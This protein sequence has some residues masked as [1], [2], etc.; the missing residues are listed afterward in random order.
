MSFR[1][2][3]SLVIMLATSSLAPGASGNNDEPL[4]DADVREG[5]REAIEYLYKQ[6]EDWGHWDVEEP[7]NSHINGTNYGGKTA[8]VTYALLTAGESYQNEKLKKAIAFLKDVDLVGTYA[9]AM[10]AHVWAKMPEEY[11]PELRRDL[12]WLLDSLNVKEGTYDYYFKPRPGRVDHSVTQY[13]ML[14]VWEAAKRDVPVSEEYWRVLENHFLEAQ[15]ADGGW[16]YYN[17]EEASYG[18]M[19]AAGLTVLYVTQDYLHGKDYSR[20]G[21]TPNHPLQR[22]INLGLDWLARYY[23]PSINPMPGR[24]RSVKDAPRGSVG[25]YLYG[26]ER[27]GLASGLKFFNEEDWYA[28]GARHLLDKQYASGSIGGFTDTAFALMFLVRGRVPVFINKLAIDGFHWNNRPRDAANLTSWVSDQVENEM[29]WQIVPVDAPVEKWM[30]APILYLA[31]HMPLRFEDERLEL[32]KEMR[33]ALAPR[34][35]RLPK[36]ADPRLRRRRLADDEE[37]GGEA[38]PLQDVLA[39][40]IK[41][42]IDLGGTLL[43]AADDGNR[44][45]TR[46]VEML[47]KRLYPDYEYKPID[48]EDPVYNIVFPVQGRRVRLRSVHN[49]I[50]H[51]A[52]HSDR[53]LSWLLHSNTQRDA[54]RWQFMA[55]LYYY[56]T[57]KGDIRPKLDQHF[58]PRDP[59]VKPRRT[60]HVARVRHAGN[61]NPEPLVWERQ[62]VFMHNDAATDVQVRVVNMADLADAEVSFAHI[63]GTGEVTFTPEQVEALQ[64][65]ADKGGVVLLE[66]AGGGREFADAA[67][68]MVRKAYG[69]RRLLPIK[70]DHPTMTGDGIAEGYDCIEVEYRTF[71][72]LR[73][74]RVNTPRLQSMPVD[75]EPRIIVSSEDLTEG[76]LN[77][78]VWGVFGYSPEWSRKLLSN[79]VHWAAEVHPVE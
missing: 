67:A 12:R 25:Y 47:M 32:A 26:V 54:S 64:A 69:D 15:R 2:T 22:H 4:T 73:M 60:V 39:A 34:I 79:L 76:V 62:G 63:A 14:G 9:V 68:S 37:D 28:A 27:V 43:T 72:V 58:E 8:L 24:G 23:D 71:A 52:I 53:D 17:D 75:D 29:I 16:N 61:W 74:G 30:D 1:P 56:A 7:T 13:G 49:G 66:S 35:E 50:R 38:L 20:T 44:N 51:L 11:M 59:E 6:Q 45:F 46:S 48:P 55:N 78:P 65:F 31:S 57:E 3:L 42:Y 36:P 19:T 40:Q 10:R 18:S 5:I 41:R 33:E 21:R 77:Q 70:L